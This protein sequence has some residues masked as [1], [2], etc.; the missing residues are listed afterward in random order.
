MPAEKA[1]DQ[2]NAAQ[3]RAA[4]DSGAAHDKVNFPDPAAA[5]LGTDAEA[6]GTPAQPVS[7]EA[8]APAGPRRRN[9]ARPVA[10]GFVALIL[11][12]AAITLLIF[13]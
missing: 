8:P 9:R 6:G 7:S 5:P 12:S 3:L 10:L 4:I 1:P 2:P 11:V 13:S